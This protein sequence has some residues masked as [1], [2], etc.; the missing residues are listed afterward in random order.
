[1]KIEKFEAFASYE[2]DDN[3]CKYGSAFAYFPFKAAA[4]ADLSAR[5]LR[6]YGSTRRVNCIRLEDTIYVLSEDE[7]PIKLLV[8]KCSKYVPLEFYEDY[9]YVNTYRDDTKYYF[10]DDLVLKLLK[11]KK[12]HS[13]KKILGLTDDKYLYIL[14]SD[15]PI[16]IAKFAMSRELAVAHARSKL[17]EE[18]KGL[19]GLS[20]THD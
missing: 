19:L 3:G 8:G 16:T 1:M 18:E 5:N 4:E 9:C 17:T 11:D 14:E 6:G 12:R 20:D 2:T 15:V 10:S 13:L 7:K